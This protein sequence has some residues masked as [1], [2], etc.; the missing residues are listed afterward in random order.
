VILRMSDRIEELQQQVAH[1]EQ[2]LAA[3]QARS[4]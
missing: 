2:Q 3:M 4:R 1:L